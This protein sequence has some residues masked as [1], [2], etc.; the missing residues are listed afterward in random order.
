MLGGLGFQ[1]LRAG[2]VGHKSNVDV[3]NISPALLSSHL[4]D[5][6]KEGGGLHVSHGAADLGDHHIGSGFLSGAV[7]LVLDLVG[8]V[9]DDLDSSAKIISPALLGDN[10]PVDLSGGHVGVYGQ[11]LVNETLIVSKVKISF[12]TVISHKDLAMLEW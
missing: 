4:T 5:R 1:L 2:D 9:R 3:A 6:L 12:G 8:D 7:D 11:I 10:V